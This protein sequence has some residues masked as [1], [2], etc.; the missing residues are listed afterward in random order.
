MRFLGRSTLAVC[1]AAISTATLR[2]Q[3]PLP[4]LSESDRRQVVPFLQGT[5][6]FLT[7]PRDS[8]KFEAD[9]QPNFVIS[10]FFGPADHRRLADRQVQACLL[11]C[12]H[13]ACAP[14]RARREKRA[15][16][17]AVLHAEGQ[18]HGP[19]FSW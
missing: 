19:L 5:Y 12:R 15:G 4:I 13:A 17:D 16:P 14:S 3:E 1:L 18:L 6:V 10:Q 7:I 11:H 9:I 8:I 2:A